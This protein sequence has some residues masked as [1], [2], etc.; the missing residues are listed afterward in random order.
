MTLP[1]AWEVSNRPV[2]VHAAIIAY[3]ARRGI[4]H[5]IPRI[6]LEIIHLSE[7]WDCPFCGRGSATW[8]W[9]ACYQAI[10][11]FRVDYYSHFEVFHMMVL[12]CVYCAV[13]HRQEIL[14]ARGW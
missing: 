8:E 1:H 14:D 5:R 12:P 10:P 2:N 4:F 9:E 3:T 6:V 13:T 11:N 7:R